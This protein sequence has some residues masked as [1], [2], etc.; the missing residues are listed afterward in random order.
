MSAPSTPSRVHLDR[1]SAASTPSEHQGMSPMQLTPRSKVKAML[2]ALDD[3]D[4]HVPVSSR[5][6]RAGNDSNSP[7]LKGHETDKSHHDKSVPDT[8][9]ASD[10]DDVRCAPR[11]RLAARLLGQKDPIQVEE[12]GGEVRLG[13]AYN[14]IK[15]QLLLKDKGERKVPEPSVSVV[16]G[17]SE[18][19]DGSEGVATPRRR[20]P[21]IVD[22]DSSQSPRR[23]RTRTSSRVSSPGLFISPRTRSPSISMRQATNCGASDD[24]LPADPLANAKLLALVTRRREERQREQATKARKRSERQAQRQTLS[25]RKP[26]SHATATMGLSEGDSEDD[27]V[28][29]RKL[30]QQARPTRKASKKALEDMNRETQR[31]SR[32]MQLAHQAKTKKKITKESLFARFNFRI[33]TDPTI[34]AGHAIK[35]PR[36]S[37]P[38]YSSDAARQPDND[39]PPTSPASLGELSQPESRIMVCNTSAERV[40]ADMDEELPSMKETTSQPI[41]RLEKGKTKPTEDPAEVVSN[42]RK[43]KDVNF[44]HPAS[45]VRIPQRLASSKSLDDDADTDSDLE[46]IPD[47]RKP[48]RISSMFDRLPAQSKTEGRSLQTLYALAHLASPSKQR[49]KARASITP[50]ELGASLQQ[51]AR[52]QAAQERAEKLQ[53]LKDRGIVVQTAE[54][55]ERD[56]AEVEDLLAKARREGDEILKKE[57][58]AAKKERHEN[59]DVDG[60]GD[61]SEEDEEYQDDKADERLEEISGSEEE[62]M[63]EGGEED[64]DFDEVEDGQVEDDDE[65][66]G[67]VVD[68]AES[69]F[70]D[71]EADMHDD[72]S[73]QEEDEP[74]PKV[75]QNKRRSKA[76]RVIYDEDDEDSGSSGEYA[77]AIMPEAAR[78]PLIAGLSVLNE[79]PMGLTQAFAATMAD[80][81]PQSFNNN[82]M[83]DSLNQEQDSL[84]FLGPVPD[85]DFPMLHLD[86]DQ[87][88]IADSQGGNAQNVTQATSA[89]QEIDIHYSQSQVRYDTVNDMEVLPTATQYSDI[90]DPTQDV[91]FGMS[92]PIAGRFLSAPPSTVD[93]VLLSGVPRHE[94]PVVERKGRLRRRMETVPVLSDVDE[95]DAPSEHADH[96]FEI[97]ANVFDVMK[98][99][100]RKSMPAQDIFDRKKSDAK[101]MVEEQAEESEDEYAGLGGASDN[102]SAAEEDEEMRQMIDE[103]DV[104]VD[105]RHIAAFYADK[106]RARDEKAVEKLFK[107]IN[108]GLLRRKRGA[109]FD[110]SDSDDD[111]EAR[112]RMK[113][114]EF[115]KMRKAL[116][117]DGNISKIAENPKK[118]AFLRAIEDREQDEDLDF[119]DQPEDSS[120]MVPDSQDAETQPQRAISESAN[121]KHKRPLQASIP[122]AANRPP[123][124]QRRVQKSKKPSTLAEIR[125]SVS[126][127]IEEPDAIPPQPDLE[128]SD[129]G[130]DGQEQPETENAREPFASRR[131]TNPVIDRIT[132]KR[133]ESAGT[134]THNTRLAFHDPTSGAAPTGFRVPSLLRRATTQNTDN[135]GVTT[136][137]TE[138]AAGGSEKGDFIKR[139]GTKKSSINYHARET[140]RSKVLREAERKRN[141][142]RMRAAGSREGILG[143]LGAGKFE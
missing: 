123:A 3:A 35:T 26:V 46:I 49:V 131:R 59:G 28:G 17:S 16:N 142:G 60:L 30:T 71:Q 9:R 21:A 117:E 38:L 110:L 33:G 45:H 66:G 22:S 115:A 5:Q 68:V 119:L 136:A 113:R 25:N 58:D 129:D 72:G 141:E 120:Q 78:N 56:Q 79:A 103:G 2:A 91:G 52:Q 105:E 1:L 122:D 140:A 37:S 18:D 124:P 61:S 108:S 15:K 118:V 55:R 85:P 54:E 40:A 42:Q 20:R 48:R 139:G 23:S 109:E 81:Q 62:D 125:E 87:E 53:E 92:S 100:A 82:E 90:P 104:K 96:E 11:G 8:P 88:L 44:V 76:T 10:C 132:L 39:T 86:A 73:D 84:S 126:F 138:R 51:R 112:R 99:A 116:L 101:G 80:T 64:V 19:E 143:R 130:E 47:P 121:V 133:A 34:S 74:G 14:R 13:D 98:N 29:E 134:T 69:G 70:G 83:F 93:T 97:S 12:A 67:V 135:H 128:S 107:D 114:R 102:E 127:L 111:V 50:A 24:D 7:L 65:V 57:K 95:E 31:M 137:S 41:G 63:D 106:E 6:Q 27:A 4:L 94:S 36:P 77:P 89:M 32:N 75:V 43:S